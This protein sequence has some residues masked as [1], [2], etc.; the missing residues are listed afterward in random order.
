MSYSEG[1]RPFERASKSSHSHI[2]NDESVKSFLSKCVLPTAAEDVD[3][4]SLA[5]DLIEKPIDSVKGVIAIDGGYQD[6][7][8]REAF[9]SATFAFLQLGALYFSLEDL[10]AL[11]PKPFIA[12]E[13]ISKLKN[14]DRLKAPIPTKTI[15]V[16][17]MDTFVESF[18]FSIFSLLKDNVTDGL[19]TLKWFIFSEFSP[20]KMDVWELASC[21]NANCSKT[22]IP[23]SREGLSD[24]YT[25]PC[26]ACNE[27]IFLTDVFRLHEVADEEVGASGALGYLTTTLEQIVMLIWLKAIV[28]QAP[29]KLGEF[30]FVKDGPLA[31]FG[32]TANLH[33]P[34]LKLV[35]HLQASNTLFAV[36]LEKSGAFVEHAKLIEGKLKPN[37]FLI[38]DNDYIYKHILPGRSES[39][40]AYGNTTYYGAKVI[41]KSSDSKVYVASVPVT[42]TRAKYE[43]D[44]IPNLDEIL[45]MVA[46]LRSDMYDNAMLPIALANKLISISNHPS[47]NLLEKFAKGQIGAS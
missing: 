37:Q 23:L 12:P 6:V 14:I 27:K 22:K 36:G 18:R 11:D 21:P 19:E 33:K 17:N 13:D 15:T 9:P 30:F 39:A 41:F 38:M 43:R 10:K 44:S 42:E 29:Q 31:F 34:M 46:M 8:V 47:A 20:N 24:D 5:F 1:R 25:S 40:P 16:E 7:V 3:V 4:E 32:Q 28:D 26:P 35:A 2:I 45:T